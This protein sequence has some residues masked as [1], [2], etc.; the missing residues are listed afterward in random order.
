MAVSN[1]KA[2][3]VRN[4]IT[5]LGTEGKGTI[6]VKDMP[7]LEMKKKNEKAIKETEK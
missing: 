1:T 2:T 7:D 3:V 4:V 6:I 5:I